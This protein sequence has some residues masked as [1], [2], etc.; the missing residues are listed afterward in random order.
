V[1]RLRTATF[2]VHST[3]AQSARWKQAAE[4]EGFASAGQWLAEAADAYLKARARAGAPVPLAW[5]RGRFRVRLEGGEELVSGF[6]SPPFGCFR[7]DAS[8]EARRGR[9]I[10]S[11]VYV[12]A[13]RIMATVRRYSEARALASDLARLWIRGDGSEPAT[14]AR[15]A[16]ESLPIRVV[17]P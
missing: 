7:G 10:H 1:N 2:T 9:G 14:D 15:A 5:R 6:V 17:L 12:P 8:G 11:L 13:G 3:T 16:L 4:A